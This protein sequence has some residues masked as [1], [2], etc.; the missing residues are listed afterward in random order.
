MTHQICPVAQ[1]I[2][3]AERALEEM[4]AAEA[5]ML[6][7]P[8]HAADHRRAS[9][10]Q[11]CAG[12][13]LRAFEAAALSSRA[14]SPAGAAYQ[15]LAALSCLSSAQDAAYYSPKRA[16]SLLDSAF[17]A[18]ESAYAVVARLADTAPRADLADFYGVHDAC[19]RDEVSAASA[20][21]PIRAA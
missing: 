3:L 1:L 14:A 15:I 5:R 21:V 4:D 16:E 19:P 18:L 13:R 20:D 6:K 12:D 7:L 9:M 2:P 10:A 8:A 17:G 11:N